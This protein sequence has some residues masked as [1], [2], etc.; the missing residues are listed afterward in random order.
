MVGEDLGV[1]PEGMRE[2][3]DR[4]GMLRSQVLYFER[5]HD[6]QFTPP[7]EHARKARVTAS[8]HDL[9]PI[10]GWFAGRDL[11]VRRAA[12]NIADDAQLTEARA[13][14]EHAKRELVAL[15]RR[16][17][18]LTGGEEPTIAQISEAAQIALAGSAARVV[19]LALDDLTLEVE[20]LN[21][22]AAF[23]AEAPNWSR[24]LRCDI[25][26]LPV[27][28]AMARLLARVRERAAQD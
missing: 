8:T 2:E 24:R 18:L 3:M 17:G 9:P 13:E 10:A 16:E 19:G 11:E 26:A 27:D 21:T 28:E 15:L 14:R 6:G 22:P 1:V 5:R 4:S 25:E 7:R 23:L 12:G 20:S